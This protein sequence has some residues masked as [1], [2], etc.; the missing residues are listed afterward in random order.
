[1]N[2]KDARFNTWEDLPKKFTLYPNEINGFTF[3]MNAYTIEGYGGDLYQFP[4]VVKTDSRCE[5]PELKFDDIA[6]SDE[7]R[8]HISSV[9]IF[10]NPGRGIFTIRYGEVNETPF[11]VS[12]FTIEGI[13]IKQVKGLYGG[14]D[15]DLSGQMP[16]IYIIRVV[17][18]SSIEIRKI[19]IH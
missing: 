8:P 2:H 5:F 14:M 6:S 11:D 12:V 15:V 16:G 4:V 7:T 1:M 3:L 18:T 17:D 9:K 19:I 10:P 13:L